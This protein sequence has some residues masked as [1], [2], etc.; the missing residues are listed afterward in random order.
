MF[1]VKIFDV[2]HF[3]QKCCRKNLCASKCLVK[4]VFQKL[5]PKKQNVQ[6]CTLMPRRWPNFQFVKS[7][8]LRPIWTTRH[9]HNTTAWFTE[10]GRAQEIMQLAKMFW[11]TR[12]GTHNLSSSNQNAFLWA[13]YSQTRSKHL[14]SRISRGGDPLKRK[15]HR[16]AFHWMPRRGWGTF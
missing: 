1:D 8:L 12:E 10:T 9:C 13:E 7:I 16:R 6:Q 4:H 2:K 14:N 5:A 3:V 15:V 11:T